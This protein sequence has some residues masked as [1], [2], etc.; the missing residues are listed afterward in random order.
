MK[1]N[2]KRVFLTVI[3]IL[4]LTFLI[5][6]IVGYL[7][8]DKE[9]DLS[10]V[11]Q[12]ESSITKIYYFDFDDRENRIGTPIELKEEAIF[13]QK[14]EWNYFYD[15][16]P[17]LINAFI[18]IED[19]RFYEHKGV[20]WLR[21]GNAILNYTFGS[22][23]TSFGGSTITQQLIKNLT[24]DDKISVKRKAEEIFRAL[25]LEKELSKNEI[26]ETYLNVVYM[27]QNC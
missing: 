23:K 1:K 5:F 26:L 27:S 9:I 18:A 22:D 13:S 24:G 7:S 12:R 4:F 17:N 16:P 8:L 6:L 3:A 25:N 19:K 10:L 14:S 15:F 21:T 11:K 20:D 2:K